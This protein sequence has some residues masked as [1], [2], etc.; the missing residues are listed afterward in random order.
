M[1]RVWSWDLSH[2][3]QTLRFAARWMN[4]DIKCGKNHG[5]RW[6]SGRFVPSTNGGW[7]PEGEWD[8]ERESSLQPH[9]R[10]LN[11]SHMRIWYDQTCWTCV[12]SNSHCW[13]TVI[14]IPP[15]DFPSL[16][17]F[18][19][20]LLGENLT[21][22]GLANTSILSH[23]PKLLMESGIRL[24]LLQGHRSPPPPS[25]PRVFCPDLPHRPV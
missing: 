2:N 15:S 23:L 4:C 20:G 22:V 25:L 17:H 21:W 24:W 10:Q 12:D 1:E 19:P 18:A 9:D 8:I 6:K 11:H 5:R 14:N 7:N 16:P 13:I 3:E